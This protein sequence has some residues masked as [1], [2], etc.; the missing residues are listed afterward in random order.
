MKEREENRFLSYVYVICGD[1]IQLLY[2]G[3]KRNKIHLFF[4]WGDLHAPD[5]KIVSTDKKRISLQACRRE[6]FFSSQ[7][8]VILI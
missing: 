6:E 4:C 5:V 2:I 3:K 8:F 1:K 7:F